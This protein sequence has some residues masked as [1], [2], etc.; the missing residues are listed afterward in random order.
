MPNQDYVTHIQSTFKGQVSFVNFYDNRLLIIDSINTWVNNKTNGLIEN[1]VSNQDIKAT[2]KQVLLNTLYFKSN[3]RFPFDISKTK[4]E[5]FFFNEKIF[6]IPMMKNKNR[7]FHHYGEEFHLLDIPYNKNDI[8]ML[9]MLPNKNNNLEKLI[10]KLDFSTLNKYLD[11]SKFEMGNIW[12]P[13][14]QLEFSVSLKD[15]LKDMGMKIPFDPQLASFDKFWDYTGT[16]KK[17]PPKHYIDIVNH[18]VN[19]NINETGTEVAAATAVV[20]NRI[21]SI[22]PSLK[23]FEFKANKPFLYAIYDKK[24]ETILFLGKYTGYKQ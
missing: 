19:I 21:T 20:I 6:S 15:Y 4:T 8:S 2:T 9:L 10:Q 18:K 11:S 12:I 14:F 17:N 22:N 7:Y 13:K 16:C 24:N 1:I 23:S 5:N 3:W